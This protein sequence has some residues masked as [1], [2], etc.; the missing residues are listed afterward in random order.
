MRLI[1]ADSPELIAL[2]GLAKLEPA[3]LAGAFNDPEHFFE[4]LTLGELEEYSKACIRMSELQ[5]QM[6]AAT[7]VFGAYARGLLEG[8]K[9]S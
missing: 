8:N 2:A 9:V 4:H 5:N 1:K 3:K 6:I 7:H